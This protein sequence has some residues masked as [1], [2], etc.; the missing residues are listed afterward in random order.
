MHIQN[1][2][3]P[4]RVLF[5]VNTSNFGFVSAI[6]NDELIIGYQQI[7]ITSISVR[8]IEQHDIV[9]VIIIQHMTSPT[10]FY[11]VPVASSNPRIFLQEISIQQQI[12]KRSL[13]FERIPIE[14]QLFITERVSYVQAYTQASGTLNIRYID[15]KIPAMYMSGFVREFVDI[16]ESYDLEEAEEDKQARIISHVYYGDIGYRVYDAYRFNK[17]LFTGNNNEITQEEISNIVTQFIGNKQT[18]REERN[19]TI[20]EYML[21]LQTRNPISLVPYN[22]ELHT[23]QPNFDDDRSLFKVKIRYLTYGYVPYNISIGFDQE[24]KL[25]LSTTDGVYDIKDGTQ[26]IN[27]RYIL[28]YNNIYITNIPNN[29]EIVFHSYKNQTYKLINSG[30]SYVLSKVG[31]MISE[32]VGANSIYI[33][34]PV[35]SEIRKYPFTYN[36]ETRIKYAITRSVRNVEFLTFKTP[37]YSQVK[38]QL[39]QIIHMVEVLAQPDIVRQEPVED[40]TQQVRRDELIEQLQNIHTPDPFMDIE[41]IINPVRSRASSRVGSQ[42]ST[43]SGSIVVPIGS[44]RRS[45]S[46][47]GLSQNEEDE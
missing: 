4:N 1:F 34:N 6:Q 18:R 31:R 12:Q 42:T 35:S 10:T 28:K 30:E 43:P 24:D 11:V 37:I 38:L 19:N 25:I 46:P 2:S 39:D 13:E 7:P 41:N 40:D 33:R 17:E 3:S 5:L 14:L 44:P 23:Y 21:S 22:K 47:S 36:S 9:L 45:L 26:T 15:T 32:T 20:T 8:E 16:M 27:L 29:Y